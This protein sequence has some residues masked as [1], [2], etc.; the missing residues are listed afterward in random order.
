MS[1]GAPK[2]EHNSMPLYMEEATGN[3]C[4]ALIDMKIF[5]N[6]DYDEQNYEVIL[7]IMTGGIKP[8]DFAQ[9]IL[10]LPKNNVTYEFRKNEGQIIIRP[11]KH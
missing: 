5:A 9:L 2:P 1:E 8:E 4:D 10:N 6:P 3:L 11:V 7:T